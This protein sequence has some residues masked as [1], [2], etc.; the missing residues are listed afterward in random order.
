MDQQQF[1][2][3]PLLPLELR[4]PIW[5]ASMSPRQV[6]VNMIHRTRAGAGR[7]KVSW[8]VTR[9][10]GPLATSVEARRVFLRFYKS[11]N[12]ACPVAVAGGVVPPD[13]VVYFHPR[14]DVLSQDFEA[15]INS[16]LFDRVRRPGVKTRLI[17]NGSFYETLK[18][19][20][21]PVAPRVLDFVQNLRHIHLNLHLLQSSNRNQADGRL[22]D[23]RGFV[24][25]LLSH[26]PPALRTITISITQDLS[27]PPA[28]AQPLNLRPM[29]Y[30]IVC[31][32]PI[33]V[34]APSV[35]FSGLASQM[36]LLELEGQQPVRPPLMGILL[37]DGAVFTRPRLG[38]NIVAL[39]V[40]DP[41]DNESEY[42]DQGGHWPGQQREALW[43]AMLLDGN[44][45]HPRDVGTWLTWLLSDPWTPELAAVWGICGVNF[46][47]GEA[48]AYSKP[49]QRV[50]WNW[51]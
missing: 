37:A 27:S 33:P 10:P 51:P 38:R 9:N 46:G 40:I 50:N 2:W 30:R 4:E 31:R 44:D 15:V 17:L 11:L 16:S 39:R 45:I 13:A 35:F 26:H 19:V 29:V 18:P 21:Q 8:R 25:G 22:T 28:P 7:S 41:T 43:W 6:E 14:L 36:H 42:D 3:F 12:F 23:V 49:T 47:M 20:Q 48:T 1:L 34:P 24:T 32:P 5:E